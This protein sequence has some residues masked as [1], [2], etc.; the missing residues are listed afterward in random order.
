[1]AKRVKNLVGMDIDPSG[2][3]VAQVTVDGR[4]TIVQA[5]AM[6]RSSPGIVRDGEVVDSRG[7]PTRSATLFRDNK[8]L[9]KRVRIGV[10]NQK[11]VV[12]PVELP[13]LERPQGARGRGALPG[14]G[15]LPMPLDQAVLDFQ[16]LEII[17]T[18][19]GPRTRVAARRRPPRHGRPLLTAVR[20]A[21]LRPEGID[22]SAFAMIRALYRPAPPTSRRPLPRRRRP[23]EPRRRASARPALHPRVGGG[24]EAIA[25]ELAERGAHAGPRTCLARARRP[26]RVRR[27]LEG[28]AEIV[29]TARRV[30]V[31]GA[32][33]IAAEVRNSLDFQLAQGG[34]GQVARAIL[35]GPASA[36]PGFDDGPRAELGLPVSVGVSRRPGRPGGR[37]RRRRRRPRHRGG[38]AVMKAVNLI[39]ADGASASGSKSGIASYALLAGLAVLVA[40]SAMYTLASRSVDHERADLAAVTEQAQAA[41]KAAASYKQYTATADTRK[42]RVETVKNIADTRFDWSDSLHEVARTLPSGVWVTSMRATVS[43]AVNVGGATDPLRAAL[44]APAIELYRVREVPGSRRHRTRRPAPDQRRAAREPLEVGPR[45]AELGRQ[46]SERLGLRVQRLRVRTDVLRGGLLRG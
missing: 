4:V 40:L 26:P 7:S 45:E 1:M 21:G 38:A 32:R 43:P 35:T 19:E 20:G 14:A 36:I 2:I 42:S 25:T 27:G 37:P 46:R 29:A 13:P 15:P 9:G 8:G 6:R 22:L 24:I 41:E 44:A 12:R 30:L 34:A 31:D 5:A 3:T 23:D 18:T 11:I 10:A 33:R 17:D 28:D 16:P 39:P